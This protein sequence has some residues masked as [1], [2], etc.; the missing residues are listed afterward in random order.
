MKQVFLVSKHSG[1]Q[2][3]ISTEPLAW[4]GL[5]WSSIPLFLNMA[6]WQ[7]QVPTSEM[8]DVMSSLMFLFYRSSYKSSLGHVMSLRVS[9]PP[10]ADWTSLLVDLP[11]FGMTSLKYDQ[12]SGLIFLFIY[13]YFCSGFLHHQST[14]VS[15]WSPYIGCSLD[16]PLGNRE[17]QL[18]IRSA[19]IRSATQEH[20][21]SDILVRSFN[22]G[23]SHLKW[24]SSKKIIAMD[25]ALI[26]FV[27][28]IH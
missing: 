27:K 21:F 16:F 26:L 11:Y 19:T 25:K 3:V 15:S 17:A 7:N 13:Y 12:S 9:K 22:C 10:D 5:A 8:C 14:T 24:S 23:D 20:T 2:C 18:T 4:S 6:G 1:F 28:R